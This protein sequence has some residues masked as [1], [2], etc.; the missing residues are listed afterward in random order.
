MPRPLARLS[1]IL[2]FVLVSTGALADPPADDDDTLVDDDNTVIVY[3]PDGTPRVAGSAHVIGEEEIQAWHNDDI[4]RVLAQ[5]P[6][7]YV[8]GE[9]G[10]GLRP[11]IGMRGA[12][13]DRSAKVTLLEDGVPLVPAPYA[14]PAAYYFPMPMRIA[15]VEVFKG[16]AS[17]QHGPQTV[18]GAIN[19]LT[20][21]VPTDGSHGQVDLAAGLRDTARLHVWAGTGGKRGGVLAEIAHLR[22]S[23][24][25]QLDGGGP[26]GFARTDVMLKG[27]IASDPAR[28]TR[29]ALLLKLGWG[30]E[31]S[32][33]TYLGLHVDD[34][35][36]NPYRRYR[37]SQNGQMQWNRTQI[38]LTHQL[39]VGAFRLKTVA[40][41]HWLDRTWTKVNGFADS[42]D[43]HALLQGPDA[44]ASSIY[45]DILRGEADSTEPGQRIRMGTN[46]RTFQSF[47]VVS[48]ARWRK[49]TDA[50]D[51]QL[52]GG[53]RVHGDIADRVHTETDHDMVD[54][55]LVK[56]GPEEYALNTRGTALAVAA[57]IHEDLQ[58][59]GLHL[60]PGVRS[61][62][63]RTTYHHFL[64][65]E[66]DQEP[67][68]RTTF[69][70]GLAA[71]H[72]VTPE[73]QVFGGVHRGF[74]PV[75]PGQAPEV[76]P[77]SSVNLEAG[78]RLGDPYLHGEVVGYFNRYSNLT[79]QCTLSGGCVDDQIDQQFN[80]G[81]A[82]VYGAEADGGAQILLPGPFSLPISATYT[83]S[84]SSFR[85]GFVS[86]FPQFGTVSIG[87]MLPYVPVHQGG[88]RAGIAHPRFE[89]MAGL[90]ARSGMRDS[91]GQGPLT[92]LDIP[93]QALVDLSLQVPFDDVLKGYVT[94]NNLANAHP[95]ESW[96]PFGA[97]PT[98]PRQIM[99]GLQAAR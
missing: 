51:S 13:S 74:S 39:D 72:E 68:W 79:G 1:R 80:G 57:H 52:E 93:A 21:P 22:T 92:E 89:L 85:T 50:F 10:Y 47:G 81:K 46:H 87:D 97:R 70:P 5:T 37:A 73:V 69:L 2:P 83:L 88:V 82:W 66:N 25:K 31:L 75:A 99:V 42:R 12:N 78:V 77:E 63:I 98:Q 56:A 35:A 36:E 86:G 59:G 23:G 28:T 40:Y 9:D 76:K 20:R 44:G 91:A 96:R 30:H 18:G 84:M 45:L 49:R 53:V 65:P 61:E 90:S 55:V 16:A 17:T 38:E 6:G 26:T 94:V 54:G 15:G 64:E 29:N 11:N 27:R 34:F 32:H 67:I 3:Q 62:T 48:T 19:L 8:R 95:L 4:G 60:L 41:H 33:E 24:F 7:V 58:I 71:L 14:G 43:M